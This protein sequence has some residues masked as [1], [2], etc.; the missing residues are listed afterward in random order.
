MAG[1]RYK[2]SKELQSVYLIQA[3][4]EPDLDN[5]RRRRKMRHK[6]VVGVTLNKLDAIT[7]SEKFLR[8]NSKNERLW[9]DIETWVPGVETQTKHILE[10]ESPSYKEPEDRR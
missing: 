2:M 8:E 1:K 3:Y 10:L 4:E 7:V 6:G 5:D 9:I